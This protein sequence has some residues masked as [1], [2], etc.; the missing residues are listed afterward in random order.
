M[1]NNLPLSSGKTADTIQDRITQY[2][3]GLAYDE[4]TVDAVHADKV[5]IIDTMGALIGGFFGDPCLIARKLATQFPAL[6]GSTIIG[7]DI[8]T[9]A[10]MAAFVNGLTAR[11][12]E[13][14]DVNNSPGSGAGHPSDVIMPIFSAAEYAHASG[15][16]LIAAIVAAYEVYLHIADDIPKIS[17]DSTTFVAIGT[18]VGAGKLFRLDARQFAHCISMATVG[19]NALRVGRIGHL[20]MW[21]TAAAGQAGRSGVFAAWMAQ[22]GMDG[23]SLPFEGKAGWCEHMAHT[24]DL[25][26]TMGKS[27]LRY[28]IEETLIKPRASCAATISSILAAENIAPLR[29][30]KNVRK[31]TVEVYQ[32]AK[33]GMGTEAHHWSPDTRETADHSIPY[34]TAATLKDGTITPKSFS[35]DNLL[36]AELRAIMRVTEVI[37]NDEFTREFEKGRQCTRVTVDMQNGEKLIGNSSGDGFAVEMNDSQIET[38]FR[39]VTEDVLGSKRVDQIL[40][41]LWHLE[42]VEDVAD[43]PSMIRFS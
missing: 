11:V 40:D 35:N 12:L 17:F 30:V 18:A 21:K 16:S 28:K 3:C 29:D 15:R 39:S 13:L 22:Q 4:L 38:K 43:I 33:D 34:V 24:R 25:L 5:R 9:T 41:T 26:G 6:K 42:R 20:S 2:A 32:Q 1:Q 31:V 19:S 14:N 8:K 23:P 36:N 7:T 37:A 10:D 27:G